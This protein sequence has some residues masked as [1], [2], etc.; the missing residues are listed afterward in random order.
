MLYPSKSHLNADPQTLPDAK[1][2][3]TDSVLVINGKSYD[4][5][6]HTPMMVQYLTIKADYPHALVLYRMGDFYELFFED[7]KVAAQILDITLTRRGLD[8]SGAVIDMAGVPFHSVDSYMAKLI[9]AGQMVVVCEQMEA[10][11]EDT[12]Q[13]GI[14]PRKVVR[15]LTAGTVTDDLLIAPNQ[16]PNVVAIDFKKQKSGLALGIGQLDLSAGQI[17]V[18][19]ILAKDE[20]DLQNQ[21]AIVLSRFS[22][23]ECI[24]AEKWLVDADQTETPNASNAPKTDPKTDF[25]LGSWLKL[26]LDCPIIGVANSD[27]YAKHAPETLCRQFGVQHLDGLGLANEPL[28]QTSVSALIHYAR[29]TQQKQIPHVR[30]IVVETP[31]D[32]LI[33]DENC[34]KNLELFSTVSTQGRSLLQVVNHCKTPMG[35]RLLVQQLKRPLRKVEII[36]QRLD[37]ITWLKQ[38]IF[39]NLDLDPNQIEKTDDLWQILT[40]IADIERISSRI[41]LNSANPKDLRRLAD[42]IEHA[43]HLAQHLITLGIDPEA[44]GLLPMLFEKLPHPKSNPTGDQ[45]LI[46]LAH[47]IQQAIIADPPTHLRDGGFIAQGYDTKLDEL[48]H[49]HDNIQDTLDT[50]AEEER[51][52]HKIHG[53][54]VG[55]NKVSGFY[56]ELPKGQA[57]SA[58]AHFIRRQTLKNNERFITERLKQIETDYL[59]AQTQALAQEK[60]LYQHLLTQLA[61]K[62]PQLQ[63]L[64]QALAHLDVLINWATLAQQNHW[65]RPTFCPDSPQIDIIQG[66]HPVVEDSLKHKNSPQAFIA[67]DCTLGT[68][69]H[70]QNL[71]LITGPNMGGKSTFMRQTALIVILAC[72]GSF[73]PA[74][75]AKIGDIDR[76]FTRIGSADDLAS[77]KSTFMVEMIETAQILN[78]ATPKSLVLMDEIGRGTSTT[79]GLAIAHACVHKLTQINCP[80]LFATHYFELTELANTTQKIR[81]LHVVA[82]EIDG[83]LLLLHRLKAG[84]AN[85]SFGLHVAKMA[86]IPKDVIEHAQSYLKS[87]SHPKKHKITPKAPAPITDLFDQDLP[88]NAPTDTQKNAPI[89]PKQQTDLNTYQQLKTHLDRINPDE[90]TAKQALDILYTL[91][92]TLQ[93][94]NSEP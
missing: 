60:Y 91:K 71:I 27:F 72:C 45:S 54:K 17:K 31:Q 94:P 92:Q 67:N 73:V 50:L 85:S 32:Y 61:E 8:K 28:L 79:D 38:A 39:N 37:A 4:L 18:Q 23:S 59:S 26:H 53:L 86:G 82:S 70:P 75:S 11:T 62:L 46:S 65:Q 80:T 68:P 56:F 15:T 74:K 33:L 88:Q 12:A 29:Q 21:L 58:P 42:S 7:A 20:Q 57:K 52:T 49:L 78:L 90:I 47:H 2:S 41:A 1:H 5:T 93:S 84:S 19:T 81:N 16:T 89:D 25:Q 22:P 24:I 13:K 40:H 30:Q 77:G 36:N 44:T 10:D 34:Q 66:R 55:F 83:Q 87:H 14:M 35:R 9:A 76:I 43:K 63:Q 69:D 3:H 6:Q 48:H 51:Q 64:S